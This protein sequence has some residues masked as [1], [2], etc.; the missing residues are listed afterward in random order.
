MYSHLVMHSKAT[1][2]H[3]MRMTERPFSEI[4]FYQN[5]DGNSMARIVDNRLIE[6]ILAHLFHLNF[7]SNECLRRAYKSV[8]SDLI[9]NNIKHQKTTTRQKKHIKHSVRI[10]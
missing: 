5:W 6:S 3:L 7:L 4:Y 1:A 10:K 2:I 9:K 8:E